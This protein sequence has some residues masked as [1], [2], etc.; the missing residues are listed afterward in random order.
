MAWRRRLTCSFCGRSE[1]DVAKL[2]A[3]PKVY[4]C[5]RCVVEASRIMEQHGDPE[6]RSHHLGQRFLSRWWARIRPKAWLRLS[7]TNSA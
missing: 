4:I 6:P 1:A 3:G 7:A 2:V 5:D